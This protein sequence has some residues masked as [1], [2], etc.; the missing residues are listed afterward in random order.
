MSALGLPAASGKRN[1]TQGGVPKK[2]KNEEQADETPAGAAEATASE[3]GLVKQLA[4][5]TLHNSRD[6]RVLAAAVRQVCTFSNEEDAGKMV[7][8]AAKS[9]TRQ[10]EDHIRSMDSKARGDY[11]P[12]YVFV[13]HE[14]VEKIRE[15]PVSQDMGVHQQ[16][17]KEYLEFVEAEAVALMQKLNTQTIEYAKG[18]IVAEHI[19]AAAIY[20]TWNPKMARFETQATHPRAKEAADIMIEILK[21]KAKGVRKNGP[22]PKGDLERKIEAKVKGNKGAEN[23]KKGKK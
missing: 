22:A 5:L 13:W 19:Q 16:K 14:L 2:V 23:V 6:I 11:S 4:R 17:L 20:K 9:C 7:C 18:Q 10:Y 3:E 15:I 8:E 12:P 1:A 21:E